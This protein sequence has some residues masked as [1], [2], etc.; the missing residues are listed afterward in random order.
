MSNPDA[1][2]IA[3]VGGGMS[4]LVAARQLC[5]AGRNVTL[6]DKGR[7]I[8]GR[9][10]VRHTELDSLTFD[11]GAQ[12]FTAKSDSFAEQVAAW[13]KAGAIAEWDVRF[14]KVSCD[15]TGAVASSEEPTE[16]KRYVGT[17]GMNAPLKQLANEV[18]SLG[19]LIATKTRV[20]SLKKIED[21]WRLA[22]DHGEEIGDF[23]GVIVSAPALQAAEL[24]TASPALANAAK[25]VEMSGC[26]ALML[27]FNE[28]LPVDFEAAWIDS[29]DAKNPL[30]WVAN[31]S[32][33]PQRGVNSAEGSS[34]VLHSNPTWA[35]ER[36]EL[37]SAEVAKEMLTAFAKI[38]GTELPQTSYQSAH[39]WRYALPKPLS[40]PAL[41]DHN[42]SLYACG[43]WCGGPRVEGA[44][45]SGL[46][47][48]EAV[49][50]VTQNELYS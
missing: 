42:R 8:G 27:A 5:Q 9:M 25:S 1:K 15:A 45:L 11:H 35:A 43:D 50:L 29:S 33:K 26:W 40:E 47:A 2:T 3:I 31:N 41:V 48:A 4:G 10:S 7:G 49:L 28:K 30:A 36:F 13:E 17:P 46:A 20:A 6:F 19:G 38:V 34:W 39:R 16:A 12:Y 32:S 22:T 24:I 44:F 21:R 18:Q 37:D 23:D 14:R